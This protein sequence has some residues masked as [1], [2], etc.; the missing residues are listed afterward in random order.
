MRNKSVKANRSKMVAHGRCYSQRSTVPGYGTYQREYAG[1]SNSSTC[2]NG[3]PVDP[4]VLSSA[5]SSA[6]RSRRSRKKKPTTRR[7]YLQ[8]AGYEFPDG[9]SPL[10]EYNHGTRRYN[11]RAVAWKHAEDESRRSNTHVH[12][13]YATST[14]STRAK[15]NR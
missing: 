14:N 4:S 5:G 3:R 8:G 10:T 12:G 15:H 2:G 7:K 6:R 9:F 11:K 13:L 1:A